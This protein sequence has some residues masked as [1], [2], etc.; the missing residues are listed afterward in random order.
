M[1]EKHGCFLKSMGRF[2]VCFS[3]HV[4]VLNNKTCPEAH[5]ASDRGGAGTVSAKVVNRLT[6]L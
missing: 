3:C 2:G 4:L 1:T 5:I 6:I